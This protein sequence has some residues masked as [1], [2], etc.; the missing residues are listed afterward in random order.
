[1][2][3]PSP[4]VRLALL[5]AGVM[6]AGGANAGA[7]TLPSAKIPV[8][9]GPVGSPGE[10]LEQ[11]LAKPA[12]I[13]VTGLTQGL[14][15]WT[16]TVGGSAKPRN[17]TKK[18]TLGY[19]ALVAKGDIVYAA[20]EG[21]PQVLVY[22]IKRRTQGT[23]ADPFGTPVGIAI[24]K[25]SSLY[26]VNTGRGSVAWYP[27]GSGQAQE[28]TCKYVYLG[29]DVA[30]DKEG[31]IFIQGYEK[32]GTAAGVVEIPNGPSGPQS[33]ECKPLHL[34]PRTS[35]NPA[36]IAIDPKTDSLITLDNPDECAGGDEGLMTIYP[37]PYKPNS[38]TRKLLGG[39]CTGGLR[40]NA[41]ST[42]VFYGDQ[43]V[44]GG[45]SYIDS[46]TYP[47]G[48]SLGVYSEG[49]SF[50]GQGPGGFTTIPNSLPN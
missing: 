28:L 33:S 36:G 38:A 34:I 10:L 37:K 49:G 41:D 11:A 1:M 48:K 4:S 47:G 19:S 22:D 50:G 8:M 45:F 25:D 17:I 24:G 15:Y 40:L 29:E 16:I 14:E 35:A 20:M 7:T 44:S 46:S 42:M 26:V 30:V 3:T 31:D 39:N 18:L 5:A 6:I 12:L 9:N 2:P 21:P 43:S 13:A 27:K 32:R 23:M